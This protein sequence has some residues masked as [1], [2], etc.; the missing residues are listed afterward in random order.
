[1]RLMFGG[2][3]HEYD[4]HYV[5]F[6][7]EFMTHFLGEAGFANIRRVASLG[8]FDDTSESQFGGLPVS[9]N[10]IANKQK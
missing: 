5:G 2:H 9:L 3:G 4:Y 6:N 1:M 8:Q 7:E 10:M